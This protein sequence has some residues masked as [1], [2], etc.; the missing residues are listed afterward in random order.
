MCGIVGIFDLT[1]QR[2]INR[3]LLATMNESQFH[4]GPR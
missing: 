3:E 2:E 1:G 4:R